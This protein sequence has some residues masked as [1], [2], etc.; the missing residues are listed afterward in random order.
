MSDENKNDMSLKEQ[1]TLHAF[2]QIKFEQQ[3]QDA[4]I[5]LLHRRLDKIEE[6][7]CD[8]EELPEKIEDKNSRNLINNIRKLE[9]I[10]ATLHSLKVWLNTNSGQINKL[11]DSVAALI[12][13]MR[14]EYSHE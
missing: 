8:K 14:K 2:K 9:E 5:D 11:Y 10:T 13:S 1:V 3:Q 7:F 12:E 4:S 6:L